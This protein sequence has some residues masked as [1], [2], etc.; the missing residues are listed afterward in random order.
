MEVKNLKSKS[1]GKYM[2]PR[3]DTITKLLLGQVKNRDL[4]I[5]FLQTVLDL[6]DEE[7]TSMIFN[8]PYL[9][10]EFFGKKCALLM[11]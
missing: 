6:P 8:N 1:L 2:D 11:H 5:N 7:Y 4:A 9:Y 10:P 3:R